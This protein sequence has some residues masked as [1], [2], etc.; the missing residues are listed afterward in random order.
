M[1][2]END[3]YKMYEEGFFKI[4]KLNKINKEQKLTIDNLNY[5]LKK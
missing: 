3:I 5:E 1:A 4:E 2:R